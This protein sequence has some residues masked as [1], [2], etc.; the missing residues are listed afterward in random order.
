[1]EKEIQEELII[2]AASKV[3]ADWCEEELKA[4]W[5]RAVE[6]GKSSESIRQA[7]ETACLKNG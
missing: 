6:A 5:N 1:M 4:Y 2:E 7:F 3:H